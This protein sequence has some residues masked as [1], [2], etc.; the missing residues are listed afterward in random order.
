MSTVVKLW[1]PFLLT[2]WCQWSIIVYRKEEKNMTRD[3]AI[4]VAKNPWGWQKIERAN[5]VLQAIF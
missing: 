3:D 2:F 1:P 5:K 4:N